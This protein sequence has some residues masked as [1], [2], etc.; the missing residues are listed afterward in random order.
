MQR[1]GRVRVGR[2][3]LAAILGVWLLLMGT[4]P[5]A[6]PLRAQQA[7]TDDLLREL[8]QRLLASPVPSGFGAPQQVQ[9]LPGALPAD[10][11][12]DLPL[13]DGSTLIG[14]AVRPSFARSSGPVPL[15]APGAQPPSPSGEASDIVLD[16]P[17]AP[18]DVLSFYRDALTGLGWSPPAF[19]T[20]GP[21]GFLPAFGPSP[22]V[23]YCAGASGPWLTVS[24]SAGQ[25]GEND[26]RV[27]IDTG[28]AGP[29]TAPTFFGGGPGPFPQV[30]PPLAPPTGV[31]VQPNGGSGGSGH[32][33]SDAA[34]ATSLSPAEL[35]AA[36]AQQLSA[37][38]W[39]RIDGHDDG[40]LV[41]ST[42]S[43]PAS[44]GADDWQGFLLVRQGPADGVFSLHLEANSPSLLIAG[45][46]GGGSFTVVSAPA[47]AQPV[48]LPAPTPPA[49]CATAA[50]AQ[51]SP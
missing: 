35:E 15:L 34:A 13:P 50:G 11:P 17:G 22:A 26:V 5:A 8:A 48:S 4:L 32:V 9:L 21:G 7:G 20:P 12:L 46:S 18:A 44:A 42:W 25:S 51:C 14:S 47:T 31:Q 41:W 29:C 38:G 24:V 27:H 28:N 10:L 6:R 43:L 2:M 36:Y 30:L 45:G 3:A 37:A 33:S 1:R 23:T 16:V 40:T 49:G 19:P 39:T